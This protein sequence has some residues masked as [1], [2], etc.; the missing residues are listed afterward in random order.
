MRHAPGS[1]GRCR[2]E[3]LRGA[4]LRAE[5]PCREELEGRWQQ[6]QELDHRQCRPC[7]GSAQKV[8]RAVGRA[9]ARGRG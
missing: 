5:A 7:R 3:G 9:G 1:P 8:G 6:L 4:R 2:D